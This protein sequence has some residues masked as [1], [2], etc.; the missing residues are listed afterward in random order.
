MGFLASTSE[1]TARVGRGTPPADDSG[2]IWQLL[3]EVVVG[4]FQVKEQ[5]PDVV[6]S[7]FLCS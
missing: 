7:E 3:H 2:Q 6:W 4:A 5:L 1:R